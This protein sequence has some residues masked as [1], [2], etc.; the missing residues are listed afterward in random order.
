MSENRRETGTEYE[1]QAADYL[2]KNGYRIIERSFRCHTGEIDLIA[3][4]PS[5]RSVVF[6][7]VKYRKSGT[8][9]GPFAAVGFRKQQTISRVA[10]FYLH[11]YGY[12]VET[13]CRFD[14]IGITPEGLEHIKN[15]FQYIG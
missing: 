1:T 8:A 2:E 9:G 11:R 3:E 10:N 6:V 5:D 13:A 4:D 7:E 14:V 15:A 12:P